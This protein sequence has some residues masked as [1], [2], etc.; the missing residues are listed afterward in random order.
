MGGYTGVEGQD[1][2]ATADVELLTLEDDAKFADPN[3]WCQRNMSMAPLPLDGA[4]ISVV[5]TFYYYNRLDGN[6]NVIAEL[7]ENKQFS[8]AHNTAQLHRVIVCGGADH[9]YVIQSKCRWWIPGTD[10]WLDGPKMLHPRY[11]ATVAAKP[12]S[13]QLWMMGGRDGSKILQENE[14]LQY[15]ASFTET[16]KNFVLKRWEWAN[17]KMKNSDVWDTAV[18]ESMKLLPIPL[19]G[20][21]TVEVKVDE[22]D[23]NG[24]QKSI[25]YFVLIGGGTTEI[26]EDGTFVENTGPIPTNHV[27]VFNTGQ[28]K[29]SSTF[30]SDLVT[31]KRVLTK[32]KIAR[33]NHACVSYT[34]GGKP[35]IMVAGGVTFGSS[36]QALV[37]DTVEVLDFESGQW[38]SETNFPNRLTGTKLITVNNRPVVVGRYGNELTNRMIRYSENK[39]WQPLPTNL[40]MGRSDFQLLPDIPFLFTV[41]P[42]MNSKLTTMVPGSEAER[43]W[44]NKFGEIKKGIKTVVKTNIATEAWI[45]LDLGA[46]MMVQA[47]YFESGLISEDGLEYAKQLCEVRVGSDV[48]PRNEEKGKPILVNQACDKEIN[49]YDVYRTNCQ[50]LG[51]FVTI[52]LKDP[53]I[54]QLHIR[55][56]EILI[57]SP[58]CPEPV[59]Q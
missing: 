25:L 11:Q 57:K 9:N 31:D 47:V 7:K 39:V 10:T 28:N 43:G 48:V 46:E 52:Q 26:K 56:V 12:A 59:S 30:A 23:A 54:T 4:T 38:K 42:N 16:K 21:C 58:T 19:T 37:V 51:R 29:W 32:S 15:P 27:H 18:P 45:Q 40:L 24:K 36:N 1:Q 41:N 17:S 53:L 35:K 50:K 49:G 22:F 33:M 8:G 3:A 5:N 2:A 14:V 13:G 34:E 55:D 44:R 20:H 6:G